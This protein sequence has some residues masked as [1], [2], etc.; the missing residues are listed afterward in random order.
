LGDNPHSDHAV[1]LSKGIDARIVESRSQRPLAGSLITSSLK[2]REL[3]RALMNLAS[4]SRSQ[5]GSSV[6]LQRAYS[7]GI[8]SAEIAVALVYAGME[9]AR[10]AGQEEVFYVSREG[11]FLA[12]VHRKVRDAI[13]EFDGMRPVHLRVSRRSTFGASL[14]KFDQASLQRMWSQYPNQSLD[15]LLTSVGVRS[16]E[17]EDIAGRMGLNMSV[18]RTS[19]SMDSG[20]LEF[21]EHAEVRRRVE[22]SFGEQRS[23][24]KEYLAARGFGKDF[25]V[26]VDV[27]WRG[28]IQD[29]LAA[30]LPSTHLHGM[31]VGLFPFLNTQFTNTSKWA[32]CF[33][34]NLGERFDFVSPPAALEAP[35]TPVEDSVVGYRREADGTIGF[36]TLA[37]HGR[38]DDLVRAFQFGVH[39][40]VN[41]VVEQYLGWGFDA[42]LL[43][44]RCSER[45]FEYFN[46]P[47]GG[48]ADIWFEST[49]D[50]SFGALNESPFAKRRDFLSLTYGLSEP[51]SHGSV[52]DSLWPAGYLAWR[53]ARAA[54]LAGMSRVRSTDA[55]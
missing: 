27:G 34:G 37:E 30:L 13:H 25:H 42:M 22:A 39:A 20:A 16:S 26:V 5:V 55:K 53:P 11:S 48:V 29:N 9:K 2:G 4:S 38:A 6:G 50:D 17:F 21:L 46:Q 33:D 19:I 24:L 47:L 14:K 1:P 3:D 44:E 41:L 36:A 35:W 54:L 10:A 28:T 51:M 7:A 31:Y 23:L 49:H 32:L 52:V 8:R 40:A 15:A 12:G 45:V 43:R 18:Q